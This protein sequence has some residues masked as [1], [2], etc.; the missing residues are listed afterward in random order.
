MEISSV[1]SEEPLV[2]PMSSSSVEDKITPLA[3]LIFCSLAT[4]P[5][6]SSLVRKR[7][8]ISPFTAPGG[9]K[10]VAEPIVQTDDPLP[11]PR[12]KLEEQRKV[13]DIFK[14]T[15][16]G[17]VGL[18]VFGIRLIQ[19]GNEIDHIHP[20]AF[21]LAAPREYLRMIFYSGSDFKIGH[22]MRGVKKGMEREMAKNN[23]TRYVDD[24]AR[25]F[26]K[27]PAE[28]KTM[29]HTRSW[30]HLV[31]YLFDITFEYGE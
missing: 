15:A 4:L 1:E 3:L 30:R 14:T 12:C 23:L 9:E 6:L 20:F 29:I 21:L 8:K 31:H 26:G 11:A 13:E 19:V 16:E 10:V 24:F 18:Y 7:N 2:Y 27:N 22:V 5:I 25:S 28:I 17:G